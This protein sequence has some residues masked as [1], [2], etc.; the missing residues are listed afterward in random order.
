MALCELLGRKLTPSQPNPLQ[1]PTLITALLNTVALG[2]LRNVI[3]H[4]ILT[5]AHLL[6]A[7][8]V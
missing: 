5:L 1:V 8:F 3:D 2:Q 7:L 6:N 4:I